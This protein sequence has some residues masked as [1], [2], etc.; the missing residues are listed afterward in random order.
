[1]ISKPKISLIRSLEHKKFRQQH[2]LFIAEGRKI[3]MEILKSSSYEI[4]ELFL[5]EESVGEI[6]VDLLNNIDVSVISYGTL[7][8][9]SQLTTPDFGLAVLQIPENEPPSV[10]AGKELFLL[11][12]SIRDPGNLGTMIRLCDWFGVNHIVCSEDTADKYSP[13]VIQATMGSF[14]RVGVSYTD[15]VQWLK[16][17]GKNVSV[18]GTVLNGKPL[19]AVEPRFP[20]VVVIGNESHGIS[21]EMM[22]LVQERIFIPGSSQS[23]AESLNA[24]MAAGIV[25]YEFFKSR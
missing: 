8:R 7:E 13:K 18:Y 25:L 24:A 5:L 15:H 14:C 2:S 12:D 16:S 19:P 4:S 9:I 10:P 11:L 20:A 22:Y 17:L 21:D 23:L 1:M 3:I 6:P